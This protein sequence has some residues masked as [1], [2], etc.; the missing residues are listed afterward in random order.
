MCK[1][2]NK[3]VKQIKELVIYN[4]KLVDIKKW[5]KI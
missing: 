1:L 3:Q 5:K 4:N 2:A